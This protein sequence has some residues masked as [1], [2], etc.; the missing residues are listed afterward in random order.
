VTDISKNSPAQ[1]REH[2]YKTWRACGQNITETVRELVSVG[3][4]FS[5]KTITE[6]CEKYDWKNRAARAEAEEA[7]LSTELDETS[8]LTDLQLIRKRYKEAFDKMATGAPV[9]N[10]TAYAFAK[11]CRAIYDI[12]NKEDKN[13]FR[14]PQTEE[15]PVDH[16]AGGIDEL[17]NAIRKE[18]GALLADPAKVNL[19]RVKELNDAIDLIEHMTP[20][21]ERQSKPKGLSDETAEQIRRDILGVKK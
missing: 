10:Q 2:A 9:D 8:I 19:K 16:I 20:P 6:W 1:N 12:S 11:V 21:V 15:R 18:I 17:K 3:F 13:G 5:R 14:T 4:K 7:R